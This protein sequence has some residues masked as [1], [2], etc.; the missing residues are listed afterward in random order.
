MIT[1]KLDN[2]RGM[3]ED[4]IRV[5]EIEKSTDSMGTK[6]VCHLFIDLC[7]SIAKGVVVDD[8]TMSIVEQQMDALDRPDRHNV[9]GTMN[10]PSTM[11]QIAYEEEGE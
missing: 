8:F 7:E 11:Q 9:A 1:V 2:L 4:L 10:R 3:T 5:K 6:Q